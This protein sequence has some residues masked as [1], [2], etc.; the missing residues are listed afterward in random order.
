MKEYFIL[1]KAA[2]DAFSKLKNCDRAKS[3]TS[4]WSGV[5]EAEAAFVNLL[6][7]DDTCVML[8]V[9]EKRGSTK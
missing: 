1:Y 6:I 5:V 2:M 4:Y 9:E 8:D 3:D 7:N